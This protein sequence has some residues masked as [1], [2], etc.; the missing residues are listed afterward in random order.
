MRVTALAFSL[1]AICSAQTTKQNTLA[2]DTRACQGAFKSLKYCDT[3]LNI[4]DRVK[5]FIARLWAN[6]STI[7]PQLTARHNGG[8]SPGPSD[9]VEELGLPEFDWGLN[10]LHGVQSS[11]VSSSG[12]IYCPTS[13]MSPVNFGSAWDD[14]GLLRFAQIVSTEARALWLAGA[15]EESTWS[16]RGHIAPECWS[17][18]RT[19]FLALAPRGDHLTHLSR[20]LP[21][22]QHQPRPTMGA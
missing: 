4:D 19:P 9:A 3:T 12:K 13:F 15:V 5:D 16:G 14:A 22:H 1:T 11:C 8:S 20:P 21:E 10:C 18:V 2:Y 17:P 6:T 7:A